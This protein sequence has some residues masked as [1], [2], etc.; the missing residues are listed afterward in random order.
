M[1]LY[2]HRGSSGTT[3]ENTLAAF[4]Q[5]LADG[6]DGVEFDVR[7]T[8][9]G[10]PVLLHDRDLERTTDGSGPIDAISAE[11]LSRVRTRG[12]EPVPP[13]AEVL[14]AVGDRLRLNAELKQ[15]GIEGPVLDALR[16]H[17]QPG[18]F[19]S[20]FDWDSLREARRLDPAAPIWPLAE[21]CDDALLA[22]AAELGSPGVSLAAAA[23]DRFAADRLRQA[24]LAVGVWTVNDPGEAFRVR[25]LGAAIVMTD[26]PAA[27]R[28]ALGAG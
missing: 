6:A 1:L 9:D 24:G 23:F 8:A 2:A 19:V 28:R 20:S 4:R 21:V 5:A 15:P 3:P 12:G 11:D 16:G 26:Q 27:I 17:A 7:A 18:S 25:D 10:V 14:V 22:V 13:L